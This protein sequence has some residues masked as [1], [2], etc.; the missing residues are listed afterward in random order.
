MCTVPGAS[1]SV[2]ECSIHAARRRFQGLTSVL[3]WFSLVLASF[4]VGFAWASKRELEAKIDIVQRTPGISLALFF[5][6]S[7][8][9]ILSPPGRL[10]FRAFM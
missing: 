8:G 4:G 2:A 7:R 9:D 3:G 1:C 10:L 5:V 6:R